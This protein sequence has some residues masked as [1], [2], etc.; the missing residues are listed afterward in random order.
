MAV[1]RF[2]G[3][4]KTRN[5]VFDNITPNNIVVTPS[6][7]IAVPAGEFKPANWL[8]VAWQGTASQDYFVISSGKV[9]SLTSQGEIVPS[10]YK[11]KAEGL[12]LTDTLITY[13]ANDVTAKTIDIVTG[14]AVTAAGTRSLQAV[15]DGIIERGLI[16]AG[17]ARSLSDTGDYVRTTVADV[18]AVVGAYISDPVGVA[19]YDVYHWAGDAYD[20]EGGLNFVNYQ[21]QHL[22]QFFTQAQMQMPVGGI[23]QRTSKDLSGATAYT[24]SAAHG[25]AFPVAASGTILWLTSTQLN[26]LERYDDSS[27]PT[28]YVAAGSAIVGFALQG[29]GEG[30]R[31]AAHTSR[32]K[33]VDGNSVLSARK[34]SVADL[35]QSGDFFFDHNANMVLVYSGW[36]GGSAGA[37][38]ASMSATDVSYY[39][40]DGVSGAS[41]SWQQVAAIGPIEPGD[42]VTFDEYS[43]FIPWD[44]GS[45]TFRASDALPTDVTETTRTIGRCIAVKEEPLGLLERVRTAFDGTSFGASM[46]MPGS[47]TSGYTDL[48]TLS[49]ETVSNK[50]AIINVSF[51]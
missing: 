14:E 8:P 29:D 47:A 31:L 43:N 22:V 35:T 37:S 4:F 20:A 34:D 46:Q 49:N 7:G 50:V 17:T 13:T 5:D 16:T 33:F 30:G 19:G 39:Y 41:S 27:K 11:L 48:L 36:S 3:T 1:K 44:G 23:S 45:T 12:G 40:Y 38:I 26:A 21:K 9:V 2:S 51:V 18:R 25:T 42:Y 10:G 32:T 24:A 28:F 6:G 15:S